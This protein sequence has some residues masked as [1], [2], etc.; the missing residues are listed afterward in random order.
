MVKFERGK[1]HFL[2]AMAAELPDRRLTAT[3][4]KYEAAGIAPTKE[5]CKTFI[6]APHGKVPN[7]IFA[8]QEQIIGSITHII[9]VVYG[10][11]LIIS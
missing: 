11:S 6:G 4:Q 2:R 1:N 10:W 3:P 7:S 8:L 5:W 9:R